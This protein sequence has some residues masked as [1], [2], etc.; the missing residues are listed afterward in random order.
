MQDGHIKPQVNHLPLNV[1]YMLD[2]DE[3]PEQ[4]ETLQ[5]YHSW[6]PA[7]PKRNWT[8]YNEP[9]E[10]YLTPGNVAIL[11]KI[12]A[13]DITLYNGMKLRKKGELHDVRVL[14]ETLSGAR[15]GQMRVE[16]DSLIELYKNSGV[17]SYLEIGARYGDSF[18]EMMRALPKGSKGVCVDLPG[19]V[20]GTEGTEK[21]LKKACEKLRGL[22]YEIEMILGDSTDP[23]I[24]K[25]VEK[26]GPFDGALIDGDHRYKGVKTDYLNYAKFCEKLVAFHDIV[27][28]GQRHD[29]NNYVEVPKFWAEIYD[30]ED[31]IEFVGPGSAMG[32][33]VKWLSEKWII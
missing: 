15:A 19:N 26:L 7:L 1:D 5:K 24:I 10:K 14:K 20:W 12:Y 6:L 27:G 11:N 13:K 21:F 4:W 28:H 29:K 18:F 2:M 22:G 30:D 33:G 31:C 9:F 23:A 8:R 3:M 16:I 17:T 32:I 25:Q